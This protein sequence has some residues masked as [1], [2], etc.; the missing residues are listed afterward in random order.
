MTLYRN[1]IRVGNVWVSCI[2]RMPS[3]AVV[4]HMRMNGDI[5]RVADVIGT[6]AAAQLAGAFAGQRLY[7]PKE[8]AASVR[9]Y[10]LANPDASP[11]R[12]MIA[13]QCSRATYYRVR[14]ELRHGN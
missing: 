12:V 4:S 13:C 6:D 11:S 1:T 10:L 3:V 9:E 14:N 2:E 8:K 7:F 5:Q